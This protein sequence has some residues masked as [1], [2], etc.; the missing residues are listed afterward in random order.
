M[1]VF[2]ILSLLVLFGCTTAD[3]TPESRSTLGA[4]PNQC[5]PITSLAA[6]LKKNFNEK[7]I[8]SGTLRSTR[9]QLVVMLFVG[10]AGSWTMTSVEQNGI[11]CILLWG[12]NYT[13]NKPKREDGV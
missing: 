7:L 3:A 13:V 12:E 10:G 5:L 11:A 1:K 4:R 9:G 8:S 2:L 6:L